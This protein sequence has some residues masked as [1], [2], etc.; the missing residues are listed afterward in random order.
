MMQELDKG[1]VQ[2]QL[3]QLRMDNAD[4][5]RQLDQNI[6][7]MRRLDI[8][9]KLE[10]TMQ[11][12]DELAE[13]QRDVSRETEQSKGKN[14]ED[15]LQRQREI[16]EQYQQLK[17]EIEQIRNDYR[18]LDPSTDFKMPEELMQQLEQHLNGAEQNLQKGKTK[19]AGNQQK[20]AADE[21]E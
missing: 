1:K 13:E 19:D 11:K 2:Q 3:E 14:K 20:Q 9:K 21:M 15:L 5:E 12:L 17:K 7:L 4:L 10:Q 16:S 6:E 18:D 8:E